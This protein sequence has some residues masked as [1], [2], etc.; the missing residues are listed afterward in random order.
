MYLMRKIALQI[1]I[2]HKCVRQIFSESN[3][4]AS[5]L[6]SATHLYEWT[7]NLNHPV[8]NVSQNYLIFS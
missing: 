6:V 7:N 4:E 5:S 3:K 1:D 2:N 8:Y